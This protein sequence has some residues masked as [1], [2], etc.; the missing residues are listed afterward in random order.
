MTVKQIYE[1]ILQGV[2]P[3]V[4]F[5]DNIA[6]FDEESVDPNMRCKII[7]ASKEHGNL[8]RFEIDLK[9]FE[10]YNKSVARANWF[11]ENGEPRLTWFETDKY[12][13]DGIDAIYID[14]EADAP[15][16]LVKNESIELFNQYLNSKSQLSYIEWLEETI[17]K[18]KEK[19]SSLS[20]YKV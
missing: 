5:S 1:L 15:F 4:Q 13:K 2:K 11:D 9:G 17:I 20:E 12:P 8:I 19:K 3:I 14:I 16:I 18:I 6:D 10:D 7:K